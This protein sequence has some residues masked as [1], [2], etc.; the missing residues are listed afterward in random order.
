MFVQAL[1]ALKKAL[2]PRHRGLCE[3][4]RRLEALK[5]LTK[6]FL[7]LCPHWLDCRLTGLLASQGLIKDHYVA[8]VLLGRPLTIMAGPF[9]K[10]RYLPHAFGSALFPKISGTYERELFDT[11]EKLDGDPPAVLVNLGCAEGYYA[12]C[13]ARRWQGLR[14]IALDIDREARVACRSLA[15]LNQLADIECPEN[16]DFKE[17]V[18]RALETESNVLVLADC[19]G[20]EKELLD[21]VKIPLLRSCKIIVETHEIFVPGIRELLV[22]RF[23]SSHS[24]AEIFARP[25]TLEDFPE[26]LDRSVLTEKQA[27][28]Y[29]HE[30]RDPNQTWLIFEPQSAVK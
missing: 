7:R 22:E 3:K 12:V 15:K 6:S 30:G 27:L 16:P 26:T 23:E 25:R 10:I 9:A 13:L 20:A 28:A 4:L 24:C 19:E 8:H 1:K 21:P 14:V 5:S 2:L 29:M 18:E 11:L 17:A